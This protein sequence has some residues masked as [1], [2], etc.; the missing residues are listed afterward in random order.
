MK[1]SPENEREGI[2]QDGA[3]D[4]NPAHSL[5]AFL[6]FLFFSCLTALSGTTN[7][8]MKK[9]LELTS[10]MLILGIRQSLFTFKYDVSCRIV[11][12]LR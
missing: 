10:L 11:F 5:C 3:A 4:D 9:R 2:N 6:F 8:V 7:A 1:T 12:V